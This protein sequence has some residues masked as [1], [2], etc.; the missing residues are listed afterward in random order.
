[1]RCTVSMG[2]TDRLAADGEWAALYKRADQALYAAKEGG[3]NRVVEAPADGPRTPA[4][5]PPA[6]REL[7][8]A[9]A[10]DGG[11]SR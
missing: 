3:R 9:Q 1:V 5:P 10:A 6:P 11:G 7:P 2:I 4:P 8:A